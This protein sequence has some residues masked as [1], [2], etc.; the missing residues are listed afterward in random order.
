MPEAT[1][2]FQCPPH[3]MRMQLAITLALTRVLGGLVGFLKQPVV[4]GEII[5]GI[6][7]GPSVMGHIPGWSE[8]DSSQQSGIAAWGAWSAWIAWGSDTAGNRGSH[9]A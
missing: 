1:H 7:L 5:A 9:G 6:L 8:C 2:W 3:A 4:I